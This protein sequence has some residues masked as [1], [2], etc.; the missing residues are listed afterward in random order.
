M[1]QPIYVIPGTPWPANLENDCD[2]S[3]PKIQIIPEEHAEK[4][5]ERREDV[6]ER[7]EDVSRTRVERR[8][9]ESLRRYTFELIRRIIRT[10]RTSV[11]VVILGKGER[12]RGF[13]SS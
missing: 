6:G 12:E 5:R 11:L 9:A 1:L 13:S 8:S 3:T 2:L 10:K 4:T 7:I